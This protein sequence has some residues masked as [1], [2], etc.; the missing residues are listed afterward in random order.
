MSSPPPPQRI[1]FTVVLPAHRDDAYLVHAVRSVE[2]ALA[3]CAGELIVVANGPRRAAIAALVQGEATL[4]STRTLCVELCS[5][6]H[7][8]NR[9]IEEAAG[10][11]IARMDSDD[12]CQPDRFCRQLH[13]ARQTGADFL[14]GAA[15][16]M[17]DQGGALAR[18]VRQ[19]HTRSLW[20]VC[21]PIH[22][23][24]FMRR[25]VLLALGGYGCMDSSED[26]HLWL[27][28]QARGH[29]LVTDAAPVLRYRMHA[30]QATGRQRQGALFATNAGMK[31][32]LALQA[33]SPRLLAGALADLIRYS[34]AVCRAR[35]S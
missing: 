22:P 23:T 1:D 24:A 35:F 14:F 7:S 5:L 19:S 28:A 11:F 8:L 31:L 12:L 32:G 13:I 4:S 9:G 29:R 16:L 20:N 30:D 3:G 27:R 18:P 33:C 15:E 25:S 17:D 6:T 26:Y 21:G 2:Q 34:Y 10:E